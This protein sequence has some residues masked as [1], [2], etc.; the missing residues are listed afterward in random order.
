MYKYKTEAD[1]C[2]YIMQRLQTAGM[3]YT[4]LESHSTSV[5]I[6]DL[7]VLGFGYDCFIE[8]KNIPQQSITDERFLIPYRPGQQAWGMTYYAGHDQTKCALTICAL[9][10]GVMIRRVNKYLPDNRIAC[11]SINCFTIP[12]RILYK[13]NIT[14]L[15]FYL[16]HNPFSYI[17]VDCSYKN[18]IQQ[19]L[20]LLYKLSWQK[21]KLNDFILHINIEEVWKKVQK[22]LHMKNVSIAD[23]Y[24]YKN[25]NKLELALIYTI[26]S[27]FKL[28]RLT[29]IVTKEEV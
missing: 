12:Y 4:R 15:L 28:Y 24:Q 5:G 29:N 10:D 14:L 18:V 23:I 21:S 27:M 1:F 17:P 8:L 2:K 16:C 6:P 20:V 26:D 19:Y 7:Y 11:D 25:F 13:L 3:S 9:K 22:E